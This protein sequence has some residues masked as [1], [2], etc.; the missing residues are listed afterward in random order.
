M[1]KD[2]DIGAETVEGAFF[3]LR[4]RSAQPF[5]MP[6][7]AEAASSGFC[8]TYRG[9]TNPLKA[10][11]LDMLRKAKKKVF[12]ASFR[13]GDEELF[14]AL[15]EAAKRLR[16]GVYVVTALDEASLTR[17][18]ADTDEEDATDEA[19]LKKRYEGLTR[20]GVYV[21]G[22]SACHA[23][24]AVV[25]DSVAMISTANF[26]PRAFTTTGEFGYVLTHKPEVLRLA[27]FFTRLWH[28]GCEWEV[29]PGSIYT[30]QRRQSTASPCGTTA[31]NRHRTPEVIWTCGQEHF[32]LQEIHEVIRKAKESLLL[33]SFSLHRLTANPELLLS[34][35]ADAIQKHGLK[36][37]FLVR[38]RNN[39]ESHRKDAWELEKLG[40]RVFG[41]SLNH[42]KAVIADRS[43]GAIFSA[44]Y[45][46]EHGLNNGVEVGVRLCKSAALESV[47][48][49]I[50]HSID[51]AETELQVTPTHRQLNDRLAAGWRFAWNDDYTQSLTCSEADWDRFAECRSGQVTL[52]SSEANTLEL[53]RGN[54]KW[55]LRRDPRK[56]NSWTSD[57]LSESGRPSSEMFREWL[58][59]RVSGNHNQA[60]RGICPFVL[61]RTRESHAVA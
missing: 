59:R 21:R 11:L 25:D 51:H 40:V 4:K 1:S 33:A 56:A 12:L 2:L 20:N 15:V 34:P 58:S 8:F 17:G 10:E 49:F 24:F 55:R 31:P 19:A 6:R 42:A 57:S 54:W 14:T 9:S 3:L 29:P 28:E 53:M 5:Q 48:Q 50:E 30:V 46:A 35:L 41:D 60:V 37:Q 38:V 39:M 36:V 27:R 26:E 61:R 43:R 18:L 32:I 7:T 23:K 22:H 45:D 44:N 47:V 13:I 52:F 16:G